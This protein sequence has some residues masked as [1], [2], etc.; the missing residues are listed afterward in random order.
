LH[1]SFGAH[2]KR[3]EK[4]ENFFNMLLMMDWNFGLYYAKQKNNSTNIEKE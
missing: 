3:Y 2:G 1:F 4:D